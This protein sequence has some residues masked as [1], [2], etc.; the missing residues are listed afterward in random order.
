MDNSPD[1]RVETAVSLYTPRL[2]RVYDRLLLGLYGRFV[3]RCPPRHIVALY[4]RHVTANHLDI[5]VGT[6]Y[7][8]ERCRFPSASPRLALLDY[9]PNSLAAASQRLSRYHPE[10]YRRNVL[11]PFRLDAPAFASVGMANLLHC[12]P[13]NLKSKGVVFEHARAVMNPGAVL[14]GCTILGQGVKQTFLS[15]STLKYSNRRGI[16]TNLDD[17]LE[18]LQDSL[19]RHFRESAVAVIG[20]EALFWAR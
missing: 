5:G 8:M 6:G 13:G 10:V 15:N 19:R 16:M 17:S 9:S 11:E 4:D 2:L 1:A 7:F 14:F 3:W 12:L 18:D 20:C